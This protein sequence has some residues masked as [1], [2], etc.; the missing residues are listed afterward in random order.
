MHRKP[1]KMILD[2]LKTYLFRHIM[3]YQTAFFELLTIFELGNILKF[4]GH[5]E[6]SWIRLCKKNCQNQNKIRILRSV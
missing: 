6:A 5:D 3:Q 1:E 4:H 2:K